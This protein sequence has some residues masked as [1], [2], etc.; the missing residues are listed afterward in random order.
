MNALFLLPLCLA[1][2]AAGSIN[3]IEHIVIYM[4]ENRPFDHYY[5]VLN[6]VRGFND[7]A[8]PRLPNGDSPFK[9]PLKAIATILFISA[10]ALMFVLYGVHGI[11]R[12]FA[13]RAGNRTNGL[14]ERNNF[15]CSKCAQ[16]CWSGIDSATKTSQST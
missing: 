10:E 16:Q 7:H 1:A 13:Q 6:G 5:G 2:A 14:R 15:F 11:L 8:A 12:I 9:Q 4:Q 3:D